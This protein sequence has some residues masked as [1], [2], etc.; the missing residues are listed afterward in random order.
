[1][2]FPANGAPDE[3]LLERLMGDFGLDGDLDLEGEEV[4]VVAERGRPASSR[5]AARRMESNTNRPCNPKPRTFVAVSLFTPFTLF[6][7][8][9]DWAGLEVGEGRVTV[10]VVCALSAKRIC[11]GVTMGDGVLSGFEC[12]S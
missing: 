5:L 6:P 7:L 12:V 4:A 1:M 3:A 9:E 8:L 11:A 10:V 2:P